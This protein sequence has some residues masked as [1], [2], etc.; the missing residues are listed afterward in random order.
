MKLR[1]RFLIALSVLATLAVIIFQIIWLKN[2]YQ[3][4]KEKITNDAKTV[5]DEAIIEHRELVAE[6][7]RGL[8]IKAINPND[9]ETQVHWKMPDSQYVQLGYRTK[10]FPNASWTTFK[11][12]RKEL[13][14]V[15]RNPY[16]LLLDRIDKGNLD[17]LDGVYSTFVGIVNYETDSW[18]YKLQDSLM[19]CFYLHEDTAVLSKIVKKRFERLNYHISTQ[20]VY[21]KGINEIYNKKSTVNKVLQGEATDVVEMVSDNR[22][23]RLN[24][25]L[26]SLNVYAQKLTL[27][28]HKMYVVK[29]ILNDIANTLHFGVPFIILAVE[30]SPSDIIS[31]ML[32]SVIGSFLL[33]LL[34]GICLAYMFYTILKQKKLSEIKDD[35]IGNVSHELKTPVT[36]A[37]A[38]IQGMQHFDVL[39]S[40]EKTDLYLNTA[41][42][43]MQRLSAMIDNILNISIYEQSDFSLHVVKF[44]LREMLTE[45]INIQEL[46]SKKKVNIE[47]NYQ[48][49]EEILADKTHLYNVFIN[50][51]D[52]AIKYGRED[53]KVKI[54]CVG[55]I[56]SL[57]I[58]ISDNGKG[59]PEIYQVNIFEKFFRVPS[60]N[61]HSVK[62]HGLGLSYVRNIL[63]KHKGEIKLIKS[64]DNGSI[65]S[66][67]LPQ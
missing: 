29:P 61:D 6:Q 40:K 27:A 64:D 23:H 7:V 47:L 5:L 9:I 48:A 66:I 54:E 2:S 39:K 8:L 4:S 19:R 34:I 13:N 55:G 15:Q 53:V 59:I 10:R 28:N 56:N 41:A 63:E 49:R 1:L 45:V 37:L 57:K 30:V 50:L 43:E 32:V 35:F 12:S 65:F 22:Y 52:N 18:E 38:A 67:D 21:Q 42:K 33:L 25:Q 62:G 3:L 46:H 60:I 24:E 11:V 31:Q 16:P 51:L 26:D 17:V 44:N 36:T 20:L 58:N 14:K